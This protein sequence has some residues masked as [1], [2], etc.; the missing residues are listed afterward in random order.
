MYDW[1]TSHPSN[2]LWP[3][4]GIVLIRCCPS[5]HRL[6]DSEDHW[7][8]LLMCCYDGRW[9]LWC[10]QPH[11]LALSSISLERERCS[12][13]WLAKPNN[14]ALVVLNRLHSQCHRHLCDSNHRDRTPRL[15][16]TLLLIV[17][18]FY[19]GSWWTHQ[20]HLP[21]QWYSGIYVQHV[22]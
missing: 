8:Q 1:Q 21:Q 14:E 7:R 22:S 5:L 17:L 6:S 11:F 19:W 20:C 10:G 2:C 3:L 13:W 15:M 4:L 16:K 12:E 9:T 18:C